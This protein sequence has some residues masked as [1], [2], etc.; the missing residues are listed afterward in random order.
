MTGLLFGCTAAVVYG[1]LQWD[2]PSAS[3]RETILFIAAG[4]A[5]LDLV[6]GSDR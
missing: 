3:T 2:L 1:F 4:G 6:F 5:L